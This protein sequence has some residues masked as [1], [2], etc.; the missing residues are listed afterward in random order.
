MTAGP[1]AAAEIRE[2]HISVVAMIGDRAYK[3]LKPVDTGFLDH[4]RR[5]DRRAA[6]MQETEVN[7]R[8]AP[9]VY[10]GVLDVVDADGAPVDHLV[11]MRRMPADRALS[12]RL[13][14]PEA[15][16]DVRSVARAVAALHRDAP[17]GRRVA[18]AGLPATGGAR[19]EEGLD[20]LARDGRGAVPAASIA[21]MRAL[22]LEYVRGRG[23]MFERRV[24]EGWIRDGHG[25][26]L[27]DD[28]YMLDDGPR[29][30]DCLAFDERLRHGDVLLDIAFLAMDLETRGH[31]DLA[32]LLVGE[33]SAALGEAHPRS[34][35]DHYV[36]YRAHV[37]AKVAALRAA[38]GDGAARAAARRLHAFALERLGRARVRL[39]LVGGAPGTGKSTLA[40][41]LGRALGARVLRS[42]TAR[43]RLARVPVGAGAA[44]P[45]EEGIYRPEMTGRVYDGLLADAG[46]LLA[47]GETVVVD[48]SWSRS[49]ARRAARHA[50]A[51]RAA[52]VV[53]LRCELPAAEADARIARRRREGGDP[54]DADAAIA[55]V[56]RRRADPWP[57]AATVS[58]APPP[59][60]VVGAALRIV[61]GARVAA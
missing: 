51:D 20:A 54:S 3:L 38:Q 7:R 26:L 60:E 57:E 12:R 47:Q 49:A 44:A 52:E 1:G 2:T 42:D 5:E 28:V 46:R 43:K 45:W 61:L 37:R 19:W 23:A 58:T 39:V 17:G 27:A 33:W 16:A 34:L 53:E 4:R 10:L 41:G 18:R 6:C 29:I 48:A 11:A 32:A 13:A 15:E 24:A 14:G 50:A 40:E 59:R 25:D 31:P 8:F 56:M 21:R 30:L 35:L 55:G 22:A 36:A 9:D